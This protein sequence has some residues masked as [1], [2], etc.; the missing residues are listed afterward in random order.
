VSSRLTQRT[1]NLCGQL[2]SRTSS[3]DSEAD[4]QRLDEH[5]DIDFPVAFDDPALVGEVV[6]H[7]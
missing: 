6:D 4:H 2:S 7:L 1:S 5:L 3:S